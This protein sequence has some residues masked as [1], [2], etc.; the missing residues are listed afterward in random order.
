MSRWFLLLTLCF[1]LK[2][3]AEKCCRYIETSIFGESRYLWCP[4]RYGKLPSTWFWIFWFSLLGIIRFFCSATAVITKSLWLCYGLY[5]V[6]LMVDTATF[7][8]GVLSLDLSWVG[9]SE[10][11]VCIHSLLSIDRRVY[12]QHTSICEP[13]EDVEAPW[14]NWFTEC[15]IFLIQAYVGGLSFW[16]R[17]VH[18]Q[19][20]ELRQGRNG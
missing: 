16:P 8:L 5:N 10:Q 9:C 11:W 1:G 18:S 20:L 3:P 6:S 19:V 13:M 14:I 4:S 7:V 2:A 12:N 17:R 15:S